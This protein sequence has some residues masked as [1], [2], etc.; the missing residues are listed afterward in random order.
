MTNEP[1]SSLYFSSSFSS[2]LDQ[3]FMSVIELRTDE[4]VR[5]GRNKGREIDR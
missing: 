3:N 4:K 1:L 2:Y 5:R